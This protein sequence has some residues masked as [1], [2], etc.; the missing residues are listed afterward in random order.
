[1]LDFSLHK[2][3]NKLIWLK[4]NKRCNLEVTSVYFQQYINHGQTKFV[5]FYIMFTKTFIAH[6]SF[7]TDWADRNFH[8]RVA[9]FYKKFSLRVN[10][11][12]M[13]P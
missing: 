5:Q 13:F 3:Q 4:I 9:F 11:W 8:S 12:I 2:V 6:N 1:M 10:S 7:P